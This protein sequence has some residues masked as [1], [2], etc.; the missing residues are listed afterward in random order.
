MYTLTQSDWEIA[1]TTART[2]TKTRT[3]A[4]ALGQVLT[5][6]RELILASEKTHKDI[7]S[8]FS[9]YLQD[10]SGKAGEEI[11]QPQGMKTHFKHI[12]DAIQEFN[13]EAS[14]SPEAL[15]TILGWTRRLMIYYGEADVPRESHQ[16][17]GQA[18]T[19][20]KQS[21]P[22]KSDQ[23]IESEA[24]SKANNVKVGD[25]LNA[26]VAEID[27]KGN[28]TYLLFK[29]LPMRRKDPKKAKRLVINQK[30]F[31]EVVELTPDGG[32]KKIKLSSDV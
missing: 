17:R 23:Q 19:P 21:K 30:V 31:V 9:T 29:K 26:T 8:E 24:I 1:E 25:R 5:Y 18:P 22:A 27:K 12:R 14:Y 15:L 2:L 11:A 20:K 6:L 3:K 13:S 10:L 28:V 32:I 16:D 7:F 4:N